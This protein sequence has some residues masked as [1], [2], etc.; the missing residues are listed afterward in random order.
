M[1]YAE[2]V[3]D[4]NGEKANYGLSEGRQSILE[5]PLQA[6]RKEELIQHYTTL[7][8]AIKNG[9]LPIDKF[10]EEQAEQD[11]QKEAESGHD[12]LTGLLNRRGFFD[13]FD[14]KLLSFRRTLHGLHGLAQA[15]SPG[16]LVS[17][18][19][20]NFGDLNRV[21]GD[22]F[23]DAML[24]QIALALAEGIRPGDLVARFGGEEFLIY[25]PGAGIK[26]A[27][28]VVERL[29]AAI[30]N[31]TAAAQGLEGFRQTGSFGVVE[32]P[33][34]LTEKEILEPKN[35]ERIFKEAYAGAVEARKIAKAGGKNMTAVKKAD[36]EIEIITPPANQSI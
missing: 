2:S 5:D 27:S 14:D 31:Q 17:L 7:G 9:I 10:A 23:G 6:R 4:D 36:G 22:P 28:H 32:F 8:D 21:K 15:L 3:M 25:F 13:A 11:L 18:D 16:C 30:P 12:P 20:D 24:Q 1:S 33:S 26:G 35:R 34:T 29:R 19:L